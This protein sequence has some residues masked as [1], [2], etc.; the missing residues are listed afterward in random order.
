MLCQGSCRLVQGEMILP[1]HVDWQGDNLPLCRKLGIAVFLWPQSRRMNSLKQSMSVAITIV[2][3]VQCGMITIFLGK[4]TVLSLG[5]ADA[6]FEPK[7]NSHVGMQNHYIFVDQVGSEAE[8]SSTENTTE[9]SQLRICRQS[10]FPL[11]PKSNKTRIVGYQA[12]GVEYDKFGQAL[13]V[14]GEKGQP[15]ASQWGRRIRPFP[16]HKTIFFFGNSHTGQLLDSILCAYRELIVDAELRWSPDFCGTIQLQQNSTIYYALN[17]WMAHSDHWAD[18][19]VKN[20]FGVPLSSIDAVV[21]GSF[22]DVRRSA[23]TT[24][25]RNMLK[26]ALTRPEMDITKAGTTV[27]DL[28][29]FFS[30]AIVSV[31]MFAASSSQHLELERQRVLELQSRGRTNVGWINPRKYVPVLDEC[32]CIKNVKVCHVGKE[33]ENLHRCTGAQG[34]PNEPIAWDLIEMLHELL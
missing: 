18:L 6:S 22:N 1:V 12:E 14:L 25:Q 21:L 7:G 16:S 26:K 29:A 33:A 17:S 2:C 24:F 31:G 19:L 28:S 15:N 11:G 10:T 23:N 34:G 8:L 3:L 13:L 5:E 20:C 9:R 32:G 27:D 30:G 4:T